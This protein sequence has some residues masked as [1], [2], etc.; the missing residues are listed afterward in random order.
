M[1]NLKPVLS[2][3]FATLLVISAVAAS[4][5]KQTQAAP[6]KQAT[7]TETAA[8]TTTHSARTKHQRMAAQ[9]RHHR[10]PAHLLRTSAK[11]TKRVP[12]TKS[13]SK[14]SY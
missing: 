10:H 13:L 6:A 4:F 5:G 9:R 8:G 7:T 12:K 3:G 11:Q 2:L 1:K 14:L